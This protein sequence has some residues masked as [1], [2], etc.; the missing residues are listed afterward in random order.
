MYPALRALKGPPPVFP[1]HG[2]GQVP[3]GKGDRGGK[4]KRKRKEEVAGK[5]W[6]KLTWDPI[7][8]AFH[9]PG[10]DQRQGPTAVNRML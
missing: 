1:W 3:L 9:A 5:S 10:R 7:S 2:C 8:S 4:E 6:A